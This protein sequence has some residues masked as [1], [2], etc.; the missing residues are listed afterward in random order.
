MKDGG[1]SEAMVLIAEYCLALNEAPIKNKIWR[2][3]L[4]GEPCI[5]IAVNGYENER[6]GLPPFHA[7]VEIN[8][9][10]ALLLNP[11]DGVGLAGAEDLLIARLKGLLPAKVTEPSPEQ[12]TWIA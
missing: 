9:W 11:Y 10:P 1:L 12:L 2:T 8:G 6:D 7:N 4:P 3:T 5:K